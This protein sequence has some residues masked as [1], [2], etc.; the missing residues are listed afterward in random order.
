M[1]AEFVVIVS[2]KALIAEPTSEAAASILGFENILRAKQSVSRG[3]LSQLLPQNN[4]G[5]LI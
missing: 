4:L 3:Q 5:H 2:G 1:S